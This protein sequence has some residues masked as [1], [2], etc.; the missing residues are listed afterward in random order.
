[1]RTFLVL[2][3]IVLAAGCGDAASPPAPEPRQPFQWS[4][5]QGGWTAL[6]EPPFVRA[7][8]ALVWAGS[9]L[10]Y[11]G[12]ESDSGGATHADGAVFD[13]AS[14]SWRPVA[15][16]PIDGRASP[17]AVWTGREVLIWGGWS[18]TEDL[19]DGAAYDPAADSWRPLAESP[20]GSRVPAAAVWTGTELVVWGGSSRT[21]ANIDGAAYDP[22]TDSWRSLAPAPFALNA[23]DAVWTGDEI[24]IYGSRLDGN[25]WSDTKHAR[26]LAYDPVADAWREIAGYA[27]SPQASA[28][29]WTGHEMIVWDYEL[30]AAAYDPSSDT[31]REL[32]DLP[33]EFSECYPAGAFS[34]DVVLAWHCSRATLLDLAKNE[35]RVVP[36]PGGEMY[37]GPV[38]AGSAFLFP[39]A[40]HEGPRNRLWAYW[41]EG[42]TSFVP[43]SSDED[44]RTFLPLVFPDGDR[45]L[46]SYPRPLDLA[47]LGV[48]PDVSY[49]YID[50]P[51]PRFPLTFVHGPATAKDSQVA[52]RAGL[53]TILAPLRDPSEREV[54]ERSLKVRET[55]EGYPVVEA[56]PPLALS[57]ESGEGGGVQLAIGDLNPGWRVVSS[58]NPLIELRP[59]GCSPGHVEIGESH[60][61]KCFGDLYVG[62]YGHQ[63][64][65]SEVLEGLRLEER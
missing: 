26:G 7:H 21:R 56:S 37:G 35:W 45:I 3:V 22:A 32:P 40:A 11:W 29:V 57:H 48:Q 59:D 47:G 58:L 30:A 52:L 44:T 54:V 14:R 15:A 18:S 6:E 33:L 27:L 43:Q 63:P 41:P 23:A 62:V 61:A 65:I 39:G 10:F 9:E 60:G 24:L 34:G 53:W 42:D 25:N 4:N 13:P 51:P 49:L 20:L 5:L 19:G 46:V 38:A 17:A 16:A 64:F 2:A 50:D 36:P 31:W 28:V 12:G 8:A 55:P 1:M